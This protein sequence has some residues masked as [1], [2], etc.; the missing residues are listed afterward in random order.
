MPRHEVAGELADSH[1]EPRLTDREL[2]VVRL[3]VRGLA[4][5]QI[6]RQLRIS[7]RTVEGHL[8]HVFE[9]VG[10]GSRT[11]LVHYALTHG[12]FEVRPMAGSGQPV[13]STS[14]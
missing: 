12:L 8:N 5:K 2:E 13:G 9:K 6:A 1:G 3:A 14:A 10:T 7:P 4:N 11:E